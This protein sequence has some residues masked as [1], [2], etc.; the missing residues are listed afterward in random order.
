MLS[1]S[2]L[3]WPYIQR[4]AQKLGVVDL[5]NETRGEDV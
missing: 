4:W 2:K 3:D 1:E 5:L